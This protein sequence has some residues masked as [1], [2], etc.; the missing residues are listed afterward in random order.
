MENNF[1]K[2]T[3]ADIAKLANVSPGTVSNTLNNRKGVSKDKRDEILRIAKELGYGKSESR[4]QNHSIRYVIVERNKDIVN[5]NDSFSAELLSAIE[6]ECRESGYD[7]LITRF[8]LEDIQNGRASSVLNNDSSNGILV[9]ATEM[10][11]SDL[12]IFQNVTKPMV[13]VS[14]YFKQQ[15]Y[16]FVTMDNEVGIYTATEYL[17]QKGHRDIMLIGSSVFSNNYFYRRKG[18]YMALMD[19]GLDIRGKDLSINPTLKGAYQDFSAYLKDKAHH[20]PTAFVASNDH[21][22]ISAIR[23]L[24]KNGYQVP[25]DIS[26]T[27]FDDIAFCQ[28]SSPRLTTIRVDKKELGKRS[29]MQLIDLVEGRYSGSFHT[30]L[31]TKLIERESV[32]EI[33]GTSQLHRLYSPT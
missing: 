19:Y 16:N 24:Q 9:L 10:H 30:I 22:A 4:S 20:I 23:A 33:E 15:P 27:G 32:R 17:I 31:S 21:M 18:F 25:D 1:K 29:I 28:I 11:V 13:L 26:V 8:D 12:Q 7:L 2:S 14:S 5:I 6:N 3:I